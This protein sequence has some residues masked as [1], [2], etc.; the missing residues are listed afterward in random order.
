[1]GKDV[2]KQCHVK[3]ASFRAHRFDLLADD[4]RYLEDIGIVVDA[5]TCPGGKDKHGVKLPDGP[6]QPYH[7]AYDNIHAVGDAKITMDELR[8]ALAGRLSAFVGPSGVGKSSLLNSLAPDLNLRTSDVGHV[9]FKGRHTTTAS[10][11]HRLAC[12]HLFGS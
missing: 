7:P 8:S 12:C 9:T 6:T 3:P 11:I 10:E 1:M 4:L 2:L 5:S